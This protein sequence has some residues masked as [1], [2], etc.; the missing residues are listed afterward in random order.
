[1][2][3]QSHWQKV[4]LEKETDSVS[5]F[6]A[7]LDT[8]ID[9][10]EGLSLPSDAHILD[11]GG[12]ASTLVDD[13]L[14]MGFSKP[15]VVDLADA[16][17]AK[18]R[19]RLQERAE[20]VTWLVGDITQLP[21]PERSVDFWHDRAVFHFLTDVRERDAYIT[22]LRQNLSPAGYV[23]LATFHL[24][25]PAKCSGLEVQRY[26]AE[27][28]SQVLGNDFCLVHTCTESHVTPWE[29]EQ[30][31]VYALFQRNELAA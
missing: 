4:Y 2:N 14:Q 6:R 24:D 22:Q 26:D 11:A 8:S 25:G 12:G 15:T 10:L 28:L 7:H 30:R 29:S 17:L 20:L 23:L 27:M 13:V 31:F 16:A 21:L 18:S 9:I 5:W 19:E 1:M 3:R